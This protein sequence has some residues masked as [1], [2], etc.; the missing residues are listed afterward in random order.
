MAMGLAKLM[1]GRAEETEGYLQDALNLSPRDP[2]AFN[3][4]FMGGT[5]KI[6]LGAYE[7]AARWLSQSV[8]ANP[9]FPA[10]STSFLRPPSASSSTGRRGSG[11]SLGPDS[12]S[13]LT[14]TIRRFRDRDVSDNPIFLKQCENIYEGMRKAESRN[15]DRLPRRLAAIL[16][17]DVA[18]Y[19]R[20]GG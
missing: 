16:A 3:W 12:C 7:E 15:N 11:R 6:H 10:A 4:M 14:F 17:A 2:L 19:S 18:G 20:L 1:V 8:G 13:T 5:A 9:N